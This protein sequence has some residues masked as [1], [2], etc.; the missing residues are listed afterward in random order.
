MKSSR[1]PI[2]NLDTINVISNAHQKM[3]SQQKVFATLGLNSNSSDEA[4]QQRKGDLDIK[5]LS[6][7]R[8]EMDKYMQKPQKREQS[9]EFVSYGNEK[10]SD[11]TD[12]SNLPG[13][14]MNF[15]HATSDH[16]KGNRTFA[17]SVKGMTA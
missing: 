4:P 9:P 1:D 15:E 6:T 2:D 13:F 14:K 17:D 11:L 3:S 10:Q 5:D 16:S 8:D 12:R 7:D